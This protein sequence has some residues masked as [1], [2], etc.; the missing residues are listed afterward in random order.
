MWSGTNPLDVTFYA[1]VYFVH[2][3]IFIKVL[4]YFHAHAFLD[5][6]D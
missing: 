6:H 1:T 3:A 5:A 4:N 2:V